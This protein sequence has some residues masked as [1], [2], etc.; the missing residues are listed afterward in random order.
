[1][2]RDGRKLPDVRHELLHALKTKLVPLGVLDEFKS[3]GVFVN[4]WQQIRYDLKT[5]VSS[6]WDQALIPDRYLIDAFFR[7]D[8]TAIESV[9]TNIGEAQSELVEA[10]EAAQEVAAYEPEDDETVTAAVMKKV[11]KDLIDDL[12]DSTG[13]S[14]EKERQA[15]EAR[16]D[17]IAAI[18]KRLRDSKAEL[19]KLTDELEHKLQLKR[20]GGNEF[21]AESKKLLSQAEARLAKLDPTKKENKK[22]IAAL[23]KDT[24]ALKAGIT[25][26]ESNLANIGGQL[27]EREAKTLILK[28]LYDVAHQELN[29]YLSAEKHTLVLAIEHL[30][31]KYSVSNRQIENAKGNALKALNGFLVKLGYQI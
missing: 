10:V 12:K 28:K 2:L 16:Q 30:W 13:K 26:T 20:V 19:K 22:E 15:L 29:R 4:W 5:V 24:I 27:T 1:M 17:A 25:K 3:A 18:E 6:G 31:H 11:L 8:A 23:E 9:E 21:T 14:A 7:A